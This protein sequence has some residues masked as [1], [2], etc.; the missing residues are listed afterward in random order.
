MF[1]KFSEQ[2]KKSAQPATSLLGMNAK[3]LELLSTQQTIFF[4]GVMNDSVK[5]LSTLSDQTELKGIV[6]A[7]SVYAESLRE[8]MTSVSKTAY[9]ELNGIRAEMTD[10]VKGSLESVSEQT[11][12]AFKDAQNT[13]PA[14]A[15]TAAAPVKATAVKKAPVKK[16]A[17]KKE[18]SAK[19]NTAPA[20]SAAPTKAK[21]SAEKKPAT[22]TAAKA[23]VKSTAKTPAK[24]AAKATA[25]NTKASAVKT[26]SQ[27][28]AETTPASKSVANLSPA[29][30][31]AAGKS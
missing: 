5:L 11:K 26:E 12:A 30:V 29:D 7:Q 1:G 22:K 16:P 31:K 2:M 4:S 18:T 15:V 6:A 19:A 14:S 9:S 3:T 8:R 20:K 13:P 21:A 17:V 27:V 24:P 10:I 25:S 28:K 23:A